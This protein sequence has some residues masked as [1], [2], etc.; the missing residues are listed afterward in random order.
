MARNQVVM[1]GFAAFH[2]GIQTDDAPTEDPEGAVAQD[3]EASTDDD[4]YIDGISE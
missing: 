2:V 4:A 1:P 3:D